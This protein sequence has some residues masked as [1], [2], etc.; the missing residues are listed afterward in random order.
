MQGTPPP[1]CPPFPQQPLFAVPSSLDCFHHRHTAHQHL[2]WTRMHMDRV[3]ERA[4]YG[5]WNATRCWFEWC[6]CGGVG[7]HSLPRLSSWVRTD[8]STQG[9]EIIATSTSWP[10]S[11]DSAHYSLCPPRFILSLD[12]LLQCLTIL[13]TWI[14]TWNRELEVECSWESWSWKNLENW[15]WRTTADSVEVTICPGQNTDTLKFELMLQG[16]NQQRQEPEARTKQGKAAQQ[17]GRWRERATNHLMPLPRRNMCRQWHQMIDV[18]RSFNDFHG[19]LA[20]VDHTSTL[21]CLIHLLCVTHLMLGE[22]LIFL[23]HVGEL[24]VNGVQ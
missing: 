13:K 15:P 10:I 19:G 21:C 9:R 5:W 20:V 2:Q 7:C 8:W 1:L 16:S 6:R 24:L 12:V 22:V 18:E 17:G 3:A 23:V 11:L 14:K 4:I